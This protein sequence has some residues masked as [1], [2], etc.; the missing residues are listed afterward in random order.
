MPLKTIVKVGNISNLS[1]ARYCAGMGVDMLGFTVIE[2]NESFVS[3][4][5]YQ[6][7]R[8][9]VAGPS[10]VLALYG[11]PSASSLPAILDNYVPDYLEVG[12][13]ELRHLPISLSCPIILAM[14]TPADLAEA[15]PW[16]KG[17]AY[18]QV[19]EINKELIAEIQPSFPVLLELQSASLLQQL[20]DTNPIKG[21]A[22]SGSPEVR[23][24]FKDY[25]NLTDV[26]EQLETD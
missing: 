20:L 15:E 4:K 18:L 23:P 24:G 11:L 2:G 6:E 13:R 21:I 25:H 12:I 5:L 16:H 9:W 7:I 3:P 1:D 14:E 19:K 8:G 22:L 10:V 17:I 26:L